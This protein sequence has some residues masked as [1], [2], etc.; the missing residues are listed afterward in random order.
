MTRKELINKLSAA[1]AEQEGF[2]VTEAA[3]H[4]RG[5]HYPTIAQMNNNPGNIRVW[6][7][8]SG[9]PY[10]TK[11]GYV[12]FAEW[13]RQQLPG[14]PS[15]LVYDR[16]G[17]EGWRVLG[18]LV[19]HYIDG[20]YTGGKPPTVADMF[21]AYAPSADKNDPGGYARFVAGK[22]GVDPCQ[23]LIALVAT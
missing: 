13:A 2:F 18:V 21:R 3:A 7:D 1:I 11:S 8:A 23:R 14:S 19:G 12:D 22:L 20:R 9:R 6:R 5:I 15:A 16:A 4:E 17:A 10:P